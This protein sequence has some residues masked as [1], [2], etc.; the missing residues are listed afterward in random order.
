MRQAV[1]FRLR[2][3]LSLQNTVALPTPILSLNL[4]QKLGGS[5]KR[6]VRTLLH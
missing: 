3:R 2:L 1:F 5:Q 4:V 6:D